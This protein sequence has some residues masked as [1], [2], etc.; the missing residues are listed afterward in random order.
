MDW[1]QGDIDLGCE[2][3]LT[4]AYYIMRR[5]LGIGMGMSSQKCG[6]VNYRGPALYIG[7]IHPIL[8]YATFC[9]FCKMSDSLYQLILT[10]IVITIMLHWTC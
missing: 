4:P 7:Q 9:D 5:C 8:L 10:R 3:K 6:N 2:G 1:L